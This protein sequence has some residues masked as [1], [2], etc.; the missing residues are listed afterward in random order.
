MTL[1]VFVSVALASEGAVVCDARLDTPDGAVSVQAFGADF[2]HAMA[3]TVEHA[4]LVAEYH[5]HTQLWAVF[6]GDSAAKSSL[7]SRYRELDASAPPRVPGYAVVEGSCSSLA[8][9]RSDGDWDASWSGISASAGEPWVALELARRRAC[10]EPYEPGSITAL[11]SCLGESATVPTVRRTPLPGPSKTAPWYVCNADGWDG[12]AASHDA[13]RLDALDAQLLGA[14]RM[15]T[16]LALGDLDQL[17]ALGTVPSL[18]AVGGASLSA[19]LDAVRC[20]PPG[21]PLSTES[22]AQCS[23]AAAD[24]RLSPQGDLAEVNQVC[25]GAAVAPTYALLPGADPAIVLGAVGLAARCDAV[26]R[27][28]FD[29]GVYPIEAGD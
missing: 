10:F 24:V 14:S 23:G 4:W 7:V 18:Q 12:G 8:V 25:H 15:A 26:C 2:E 13:A 9:A 16:G 20:A 28:G 21:R 17:G 29:A 3:R 22:G 19:E 11:A 6:G 27:R 1:F 5:Q